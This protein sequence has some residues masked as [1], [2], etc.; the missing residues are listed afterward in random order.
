MKTFEYP[1]TVAPIVA[2]T[3]TGTGWC[4]PPD[5]LAWPIGFEAFNSTAHDEK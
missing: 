5:W 1:S 3:I 2:T 4:D